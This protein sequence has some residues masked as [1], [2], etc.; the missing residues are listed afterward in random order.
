MLF[1]VASQKEMFEYGEENTTVHLT[2]I[3]INCIIGSKAPCSNSK[4][5]VIFKL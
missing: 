5:V 2:S 1:I 3:Y 4:V